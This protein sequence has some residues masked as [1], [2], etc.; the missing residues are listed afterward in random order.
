MDVTSPAGAGEHR[1]STPLAQTADDPNMN[2]ST[3]PLTS[4]TGEKPDDKQGDQSVRK[5]NIIESAQP[6]EDEQPSDAEFRDFDWADLQNRYAKEVEAQTQIE[7]KIQEEFNQ[8]MDVCNL[9][10]TL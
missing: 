4:E 7:H 10:I 5:S 9:A 1:P 6:D 2:F 3:S 8:L